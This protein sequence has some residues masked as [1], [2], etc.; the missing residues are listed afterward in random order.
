MGLTFSSPATTSGKVSSCQAT[1][2]PKKSTSS[3][4][5]A[6]PNKITRRSRR[7]AQS[8][9][10]KVVFPTYPELKSPFPKSYPLTPR[11]RA[12]VRVKPILHTP[13]FTKSKFKKAK[14]CK[15]KVAM[16]HY[17][18]RSVSTVATGQST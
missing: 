1:R 12:K 6:A 5:R 9:P 7:L 15:A 8:N 18:D 16:V 13:R 2:T 10:N 3:R 4:A 11:T 14:H 17:P